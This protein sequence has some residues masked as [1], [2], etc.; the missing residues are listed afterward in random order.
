[1]KRY[2]RT[3]SWPVLFLVA[4]SLLV[5]LCSLAED[6]ALSDSEKKAAIEEMFAKYKEEAFAD[7]PEITVEELMEEKDR[8]QVVLVDVRTQKEKSV[9]MIPGAITAEEF[10]KNQRKYR[11][12]KLIIY[13]TIGYRSGVY[14]KKLR[15]MKLNAYNLKGG[16]LAWAHAK[17][18]FVDEHGETMKVHVYGK[19]WDLLPAGY[20]SVLE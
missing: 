15:M 9:S 3:T 12:K 6:G 1:M 19:R 5:S 10:E 4:M 18:K 7:A 8:E 11:G 17:Q 13:C 2:R 16:V 20:Q 14:T